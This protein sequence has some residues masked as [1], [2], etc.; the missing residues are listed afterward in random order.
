[1]KIGGSLTI[2]G[3][4]YLLCLAEHK[5]KMMWYLISRV[6]KDDIRRE[7]EEQSLHY[8]KLDIRSVP[9][10]TINIGYILESLEKVK[11][12]GKLSVYGGK[13]LLQEVLDTVAI[14]RSYSFSKDSVV[15]D[16]SFN[17]QGVIGRDFEASDGNLFLSFSMRNGYYTRLYV[18]NGDIEIDLREEINIKIPNKEIKYTE[19]KQKVAG[20]ITINTLKVLD[21][22]SLK[23]A[24]GG[25]P[26]YEK[27][28]VILKD[29]RPITNIKEFED[30]VMTPILKEL[31]RCKMM[32]E[33]FDLSMDTETTGLIFYNLSPENP[34]R[35]R[36]VSIPLAWGDDQGVVVFI[37]MEY[38]NN[39]PLDYVLER[40]TPLVTGST[41]TRSLDIRTVSLKGD[42]VLPS[43][44]V[45]GTEGTDSAD[46]NEVEYTWEV[47]TWI[48]FDREDVTLIGHNAPF[49]GRVFYA[50]GLSTYWNIDTLQMA[51]NL[52]PKVVKGNNKLKALTEK[53]FGHHTP[54]LTDMLGKGNEDK[55]KYISDI[56]V[57]TVY[58]CA[59]GDYT[60]KL[61]RFLKWLTPP[62]M[63]ASYLRQD[64][65][66]MNRLFISEYY[67]MSTIE[68]KFV[69]RA[70]VVEKDLERMRKWLHAYVGTVVYH[71]NQKGLIQS[72]MAAGVISAEQAAEEIKAIDTRKA[73]P[74]EFDIGGNEIREVLFTI[75]EYPPV[76]RTNKTR[77]HPN[78][79]P[80]VDK[81]AMERLCRFVREKPGSIMKKDFMSSD[82]EEKEP[83]VYANTDKDGKPGMNDLMYPVAYFL[84]KYKELDK[85]Y[86]SY[87][88]PM[89]ENNLEGK[90]FKSF[91][92]ARIET[93]RIMNPGQT[94]KA[95]LKKYVRSYNDDYY[96]V[97][98]DQAQVE[99]RIMV[100]LSGDQEQIEK[101]RDPEKD[102]HTET[103][104]RIAVVPPH[105]LEKSV[106][107]KY[108]EIT[109]G[110]PY[111]LGEFKMCGRIYKEATEDNLFKTRMDIS[112]WEKANAAVYK[113]LV[114][115]RESALEPVDFAET[116]YKGLPDA[117]KLAEA[118]R[119]F[120]A[121]KPE[122][123]LNPYGMIKNLMHFYRLFDLSDMDSKKEGKVMR[124][125]GNFPI[126]SFAA[127]LFRMILMKFHEACVREGIEDKI[128]WHMLV[129]DELVFSAHKTVHPFLLYKLLYESCVVTFPGHTT[130]FVGINIG[131]TWADGKKDE[132]E[133]PVKFVERIIARWDAGEFKDDDYLNTVY[134]FVNAKGKTETYY[135]VK[136]Y[137]FKHIHAYLRERIGECVL[138]K[139]PSAMTKPID[140]TKLLETF[141][142]YM[143]RSYILAYYPVN[144]PASNPKNDDLFY[145]SKF[146]SWIID[147]FGEGKEIIDTEGVVRRVYKNQTQVMTLDLDEDEIEEVEEEFWSFDGDDAETMGGTFF[148]DAEDED[149]K[150]W[151]TINPA[152]ENAKS[153][154][155]FIIS[156]SPTYK[157]VRVI[158][159]QLFIKLPRA[160][161]AVKVK[162]YLL[163]H[164]D[165]SGNQVV[166]D[167]PLGK[168]R[169]KRVKAGIDLE[170][171]DNFVGGL[172]GDGVKS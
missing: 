29:Y 106:R 11:V 120:I 47:D 92:M 168:D 160:L 145:T 2:R 117:E 16:S 172:V 25:M 126:Q 110:L 27:D 150:F 122:D 34:Y 75:L 3:T 141:D 87:F 15:K 114:S 12:S 148:E 163:A 88:L 68:D 107:K 79:Q 45:F 53:I 155:D 142:N 52:N 54:E 129:H 125:A 36:I 165:A 104:S 151:K 166:F 22:E 4:S 152:A 31:S 66:M 113:K 19:I 154:A 78:G 85:E 153:L 48:H 56:R 72:R 10:K 30:Y 14:S 71:K 13:M 123:L 65:P 80:S 59:D 144:I 135:G 149:E 95:S 82:P 96:L 81:F 134:S 9:T 94:M 23:E 98:F 7:Y 24:L 50:S 32:G 111:G 49:D 21:Y 63:F 1:M 17:N 136:G 133:A 41:G 146:E 169:W 60:R 90:I 44:H 101:F 161:L 58:G 46:A 170:A 20:N 42:A 158:T 164:E 159:G 26:W 116:L 108:K 51:F 64:V 35:D 6:H 69:E 84:T 140:M 43:M 162:E 57:A 127:E 109:L 40:L 97:V 67:G 121:P 8:P 91:S 128:L 139:Q 77:Q 167:L 37:E 171:L 147:Y 130:Y 115:F 5:T 38:F 28:G 157:H 99:P 118:F 137:V 93:R 100:S 156:K 73:T 112:R 131:D 89:M 62:K 61:K 70:K 39:V 132:N 76:G 83:L 33:E 55:Y 103:A 105:K 102:Y 74:Y 143:V 124:P 86:T 119:A 138:E 18:R